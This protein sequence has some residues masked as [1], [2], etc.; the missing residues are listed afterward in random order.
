M[1]VEDNWGLGLLGFLYKRTTE[2]AGE[3]R[4]KEEVFGWGKV[5]GGVRFTQSVQ[6]R[7]F[8]TIIRK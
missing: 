1:I 7:V 5:K 2:I 3:W 8:S 4:R 6:V